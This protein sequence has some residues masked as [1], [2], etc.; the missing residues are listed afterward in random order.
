[1]KTGIIGFARSGKTTIFN[2][3]TGAHAAVGAFGSRDANLSVIKVPDERVDRL[4]EI[5]KPKKITYAECQFIDIAPNEAA[6]EDKALDSA[7]LTTLK[8]TDALV[9]VVRAFEAEEV[10]H[11]LGDVNPARDAR[12][13]EEELQLCDLIVVEKRLERLHKENKKGQELDLLVRCKEQLE[14]GKP[15]RTL[16]FDAQEERALAG[17]C[18]LSLKPL[19]LVGNYGEDG[20]GQ[21]D[22]AR[23][24]AAAADLG[25]RHIEFCGAME[26][27][28]TQLPP[29]ER[30]SF[31][32]ELGL[33]E[34]SRTLFLQTAYDLLGLM[35]FLTAGEPE[36][37]A[38]TV[39]KG[40]KAVESAGVIH[41]DIQRGF[42]RAEVVSYDD[43]MQHGNMKACRDAGVLR[44]EGKDY[45]V[46]DGDIVNFRFN[47]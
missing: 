42:I 34:E 45:I 15:L 11:P 1:M 9:H 35:S 17:F 28:V 14:A 2:A 47:V 3:L 10:L 29:E 32:E 16:G 41:S 43:F 12:A 23:L 44:V 39:R 40:S 24:R 8:N 4:S 6:G 31:R 36:V 20:I 27:E 30:A 37:R 13:L 18:F 7:A 46:A 19:L 21:D 33:G 25:L 22:P 5:Y 38:W 26:M